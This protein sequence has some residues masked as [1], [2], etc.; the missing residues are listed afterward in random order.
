MEYD[1][2]CIPVSAATNE[3][4][5]VNIARAAVE[6]AELYELRFDSIDGEPMVEELLALCDKP[7]IATCRSLREGGAFRGDAEARRAVLRRAALAGAAYVDCEPADVDS[8]DGVGRAVRI[9]SMHDFQAT[10]ADLEA[11]VAALEATKA[12][13]VKFAVAAVSLADSL[14]VLA[15]TATCVKPVIGIAMGA[16]GLA[17]RVLGGRCGSRVTFGGISAGMESAPGQTTARQLAHFYRVDRIGARTALYGVLGTPG[18]EAAERMCMAGNLSFINAGADAVCLPFLVPDPA[19]FLDAI[20]EAL[21]LSGFVAMDEHR[22]AA[23]D[24]AGVKVRGAR[25]SEGIVSL[26]REGDKW[27]VAGGPVFFASPR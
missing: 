4:M 19:D 24:W 5:R 13:W 10:P 16:A 12:E 9:V 3:A 23:L 7:V 21:G 1:M 26:F 6:P 2:I 20:P 27:T 25:M 15:A 11:R 17:T 22:E 8:L 18:S 14:A